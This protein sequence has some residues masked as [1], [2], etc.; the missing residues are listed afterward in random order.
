M[1]AGVIQTKAKL[2]LRAGASVHFCVRVADDGLCVVGEVDATADACACSGAFTPGPA[3]AII[4]LSGGGSMAQVLIRNVDDAAIA[5]LKARAVRKGTSLERELRD[6]ILEA[7]RGDRAEARRRAAALRRALAGRKHSDS[8][9][10]IR[11]DRA[12]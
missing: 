6:V 8:T 1:A 2:G 3:T 11:R 12:R 4:P 10:L 9:A 7:A 5:S